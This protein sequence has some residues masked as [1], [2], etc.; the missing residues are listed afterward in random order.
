MTPN[1]ESRLNDLYSSHARA[2]VRLA[3]MLTGDREA[4]QDICH[5]AFARVGAKMGTLQ[6]PD[7]SS[8]YLLRTVVN[9]SRGHGR[10]IQ[11]ERRLKMGLRLEEVAYIPDVASKDEVVR[12]L[13]RLPLRQRTAIFLRFYLDLSE[14]Q[15]AST[16]GC[17]EHAARSLTFRG[18]NTLRNQLKGDRH[19]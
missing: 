1:F 12:A 8:G 13:W 18:M 5:E 16:L 2:A 6:D 11:R 19:G 10:K 17:S 7:R 3:Y 9:L 15:I 4:A 14:A